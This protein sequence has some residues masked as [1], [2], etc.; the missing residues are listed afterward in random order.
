ME[1]FNSFQIQCVKWGTDLFRVTG[2]RS[3]GHFQTNVPV[4]S[5]SI[6]L[7]LRGNQRSQ[8]ERR[9]KCHLFLMFHLQTKGTHWFVC[10]GVS[11]WQR[12]G[13]NYISNNNKNPHW[14]CNSSNWNHSLTDLNCWWIPKK[15][16]IKKHQTGD[17]PTSEPPSNKMDSVNGQQKKTF[18][19]MKIW[20]EMNKSKYVKQFV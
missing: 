14:Q 10:F 17:R 20:W 16:E 5:L 19:S 6:I 3:A 7:V 15:D 9:I 8:P 13:K 2:N 4:V 1:W 12:R 18:N 11:H